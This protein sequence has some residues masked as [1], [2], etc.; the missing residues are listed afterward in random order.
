M[1][2]VFPF[3]H[4]S[5]FLMVQASRKVKKIQ[6]KIGHANSYPRMNRFG[7]FLGARGGQRDRK[8][9]GPFRNGFGMV[10]GWSRM[11]LE[12]FWDGF[13]ITFRRLL[14]NLAQ[15]LDR[16][17]KQINAKIDVKDITKQIMTLGVAGP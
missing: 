10:L 3:P 7:R 13:R 2:F 6:T 16:R 14:K 9:S 11:V 1:R 8:C 5:L 17:D 12:W 15:T 4:E